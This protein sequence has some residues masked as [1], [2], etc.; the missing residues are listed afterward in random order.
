MPADSAPQASRA[1]YL[2][3]RTWHLRRVPYAMV[4]CVKGNMITVVAVAHQSMEPGYWA[5]Q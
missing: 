2:G 4:H 5:G 1:S 3:V